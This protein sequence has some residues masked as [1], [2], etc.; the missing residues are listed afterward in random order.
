MIW[1]LIVLP[2]LAE[3]P[4]TQDL[5]FVRN[6]RERKIILYPKE[7]K[8]IRENKALTEALEKV[9]GG[10]IA[11]QTSTSTGSAIEGSGLILTSDG[12]A[13]TLAELLPRSSQSSFWV[14]GKKTKAEI[15]KKDLEQNLAL[16]D[17]S[18][19]QLIILP[20]ANSDNLEK[21]EKVFL[22]GNSFDKKPDIV[23]N[24]GI[25]REIKEAFIYP[26]I[27]ESKKMR[28]SVLFNIEG[29]VIGLNK[30]GIDNEVITIPASQIKE[31]AGF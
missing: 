2:Y 16:I 11:V 21:G 20:F 24:T 17:L 10:V 31:F 14:N 26:N 22:V 29:E 27:K 4:Q 6:Y 5:W 1:Q 23:V 15:I 28:G 9:Q 8:I 12:L 18:G 30:I 13:I 3:M 7:E 25:I 19:D